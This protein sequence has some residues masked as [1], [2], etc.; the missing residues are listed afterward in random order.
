MRQKIWD[1]QNNEST[2][3]FEAFVMYRD[4]R[5]RSIRKVSETLQKAKSVIEGWSKTHDWVER[6]VHWDNELDACSQ[7][8][9]I[10][11]ITEMKRRQIRI[12]LDL[13][14]LASQA[15]KL[16]KE[17][18]DENK[19]NA[20]SPD[21]IV[22]MA[23]IGTKLERLNRDEP[24]SIRR[25]QECDFSNLSTEEMFTLRALLEKSGACDS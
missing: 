12:A 20:I 13:Q 18:L 11:E 23:D 15:S 6:C 7:Q 10:D 17:A 8:S 3:A 24:S 14:G 21:N 2:A 5:P 9:Q 16:L 4:D 25:V 1:R 22:R 19:K